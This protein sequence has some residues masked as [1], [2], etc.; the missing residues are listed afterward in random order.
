MPYV[1]GID[2]GGTKT[3]GLLAD[4]T[5]KVV[6]KMRSGGANLRVKG[7]LAVEKTLFE[8]IDSLEAPEPIAALCLGIAGVGQPEEEQVIRDVLRRLGQRQPI[9]V[10][11][12]AFV[13]LVA[14]APAGVGIVVVAGTGSIAYGVGPD[15]KT[16]RSGGWGYL[17]GDE[18][19]AF[20]L[21]HAA[22]RQGI[23]AADGRGP[24][25]ILYDRICEKLGI[26]ETS[27]LVE[28][29]YDQEL[30]RNR[31]AELASLVEAASKEGDAAADDLLD[32][33]AKHLARAAWAVSNQLTFA[34]RYP[35]VLSGGAFKACPSL[36]RRVEAR[37][38]LP[39]VDVIVLDAE[40]ATGAVRLALELLE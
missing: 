1:I 18:G 9:R 4:G 33:A 20:W 24:A 14:G 26:E 13:A 3:M 27:G 5:G 38:S 30:S 6:S 15:G 7:E 8:V 29:F 11:N 2:A 31:V 39:E 25:T 22:V 10:V 23:R 37:L 17:L 40:P 12:D 34:D 36:C 28:W 16:A 32:Q 21:G 35:I 19:S